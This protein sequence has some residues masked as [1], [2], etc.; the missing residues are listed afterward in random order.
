M[1]NGGRV[2]QASVVEIAAKQ[3]RVLPVFM[4]SL[5]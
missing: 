4:L 2:G 5:I 1:F 3:M